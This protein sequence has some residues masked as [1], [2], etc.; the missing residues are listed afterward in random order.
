[1]SDQIGLKIEKFSG[2]KY[3]WRLWSELFKARLMSKDL[4]DIVMMKPGEIPDNDSSKTD[5]EVKI[6]K[7]K[8]TKAY[9][10]LIGSMNMKNTKGRMAINLVVGTKSER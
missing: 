10:E 4:L 8:N 7:D 6:L 5:P 9:L 3:D 1:M 2:E